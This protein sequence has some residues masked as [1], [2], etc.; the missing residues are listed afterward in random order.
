MTDSKDSQRSV[1]LPRPTNLA[2]PNVTIPTPHPAVR[3]IP[4]TPVDP[5]LSQISLYNSPSH[6]PCS[7]NT[8]NNVTAAA[9]ALSDPSELGLT[10]S[11]NTNSILSNPSMS[12]TS[13]AKS[14]RS[15]KS[16]LK[17]EQKSSRTS[18]SFGNLSKF[19]L[20]SQNSEKSSDKSPSKLSKR[21]IRL[22]KKK[23]M[24]RDNEDSL[25]ESNSEGNLKKVAVKNSFYKVLDRIRGVSRR[26]SILS[27]GTVESSGGQTEFLNSISKMSDSRIV[28]NWL[29]SI[30]DE[31][32]SEPPPLESL[33]VPQTRMDQT[34]PTNEHID[35]DQ[36][37]TTSLKLDIEKHFIELSSDDSSVAD[38]F[39]DP[40]HFD[41]RR[42]MFK[43]VGYGRQV[44][45]SSEYTTDTHDTGEIA[46]ETAM[47]TIR[48][49]S[50]I[51]TSVGDELKKVNL[52]P[53]ASTNFSSTVFRP[54]PS[55][56]NTEE[57]D[58]SC[59][60]TETLKTMI[61]SIKPAPRRASY[62]SDL[63]GI[64]VCVPNIM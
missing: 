38:V 54:I 6:S 12:R 2:T 4:A 1:P 46:H 20:K 23:S 57:L 26:S 62:G 53:G 5:Q 47:N 45:E 36:K 32:L 35:T 43:P 59:R 52:S 19:S 30:D 63:Q 31:Q 29:L 64:V 37:A 39:E 28:E 25:H 44:S 24:K 55:S 16:S 11:T 14:R 17:T 3:L 51:F 56:S 50:N 40:E 7:L 58:E 34:T 41:R 21:S 60:S 22:M 18:T 9:T 33:T 15:S 8:S 10:N 27:A 48:N 61:S 13:S 49:T 42:S